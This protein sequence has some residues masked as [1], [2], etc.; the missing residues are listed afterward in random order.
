V[1]IQPKQPP[2]GAPEAEEAEEGYFKMLQAVLSSRL[3][4]H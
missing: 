3:R 2:E 4:H 1:E